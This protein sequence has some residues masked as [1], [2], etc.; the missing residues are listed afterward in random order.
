MTK[1]TVIIKERRKTYTTHTLPRKIF[2]VLV[3]IA[4]SIKAINYLML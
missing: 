2:T 3:V 1:Y 4:H